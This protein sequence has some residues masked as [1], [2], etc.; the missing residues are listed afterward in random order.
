MNKHTVLLA[1][2]ILCVLFGIPHLACARELNYG[3]SKPQLEV[4]FTVKDRRYTGAVSCG[5]LFL[6]S[7]IPTAPVVRWKGA[8]ATKLYTLMMLDQIGRAHV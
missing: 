1:S 2:L 5:N 4:T 8:D 6:Q 7:D 3:C